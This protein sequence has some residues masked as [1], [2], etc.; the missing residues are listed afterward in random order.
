MKLRKL[1]VMGLTGMIAL[2]T[3]V[4][5]CA[6]SPITDV[7]DTDSKDVKASYHANV[8]ANTVYS[9]DLKWGSME[10]VY[11]IDNEGTWD[12][13]KH[14][15]T[16]ASESGKWSCEE[17]QDEVTV[18]NHSNAPVNVS[19]VYQAETNYNGIT[20]NFDKRDATKLDTAE[21]TAVSNAPAVTAKL[22]LAGKLGKDVK[23][24]TKIGTATVSLSE[25]DI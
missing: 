6:A 15:F 11:T 16:N 25:A 9:V 7:N 21:G 5:V 13:E 22:S 10:F 14:Q 4:N 18:T 23:S 1:A 24:A 3:G 17:K 8:E 19:F 20:G 12:P 2:G